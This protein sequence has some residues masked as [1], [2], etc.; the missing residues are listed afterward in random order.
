MTIKSVTPYAA[1]KIVNQALKQA[2]LTKVIPPQMMYNYTSGRINK[3]KTPY[4]ECD[5]QGLV[6]LTS[7]ESW[8]EGYLIKQG[9]KVAKASDQ[10]GDT[11]RVYTGMR[12]E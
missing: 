12:G 7:L 5:K 6:L 11:V 8:L 10:Q 3:G 4:I 1:H 9:A 2:G